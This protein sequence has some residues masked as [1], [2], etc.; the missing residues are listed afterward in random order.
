MGMWQRSRRYRSK[1]R[2]RGFTLPE[3]LVIVIVIGVLVAFTAPSLAAFLDSMKVN[4]VTTELR[5]M[6]QESQRQAIRTDSICLVGVRRFSTSSNAGSNPSGHAKGHR[7][8]TEFVADCAAAAQVPDE[9]QVVTNLQPRSKNEN[10]VEV[11]FS[12]AGSAE[13]AVQTARSSSSPPVDPSAKMVTFSPERETA[14]KCVVISSSLG[15]ARIGD[16]KGSTDDPK[17]IT[18]EG[19]CTAM[20]WRKQ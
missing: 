20:D 2:Q 9:V 6:F 11:K 4:Q 13:F 5:A 16:Y 3:T 10:E 7:W 14:Q 1:G 8:R 18:D 17:A 15:L 12:P 19:I